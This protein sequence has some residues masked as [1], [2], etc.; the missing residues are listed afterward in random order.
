MDLLILSYANK[1]NINSLN[2]STS[3]KKY[4]YDYKIIGNGDKWVN[5]MTKIISLYNYLI[6]MK[7]N[8]DLVCVTDCYDVLCCG[9]KLKLIEKFKT[10]NKDIVFSAESNCAKD[11][12]IYL[13]NYYQNKY[14]E[15]IIYPYLNA[16]FYI[17][18]RNKI[19]ELLKFLVDTNNKTG[20]VDDQ[21]LCCMYVQEFPHTVALD[22]E[23]K[24]MGT[25]CYNIF[26]YKWYNNRVYNV[27][28]NNYPFY[29]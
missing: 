16:G 25:I 27:K 24:L 2:Y 5:F 4:K 9:S 29:S 23:C 15:N 6:N 7:E 3:L 1:E 21:L 13:N 14:D 28:T 26:D 22:N 19:I 12:C 17:G 10:F 11:K 18:K 8:Y 20:I